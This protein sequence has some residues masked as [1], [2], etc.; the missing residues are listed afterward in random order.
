MNLPG[1]ASLPAR[2]G[3]VATFLLVGALWCLSPMPLHAAPAC[4]EA[5]MATG[6]GAPTSPA[7]GGIG[8]TGDRAESGSMGGT[9]SVASGGIGGTGSVAEGGM[10]GTGIVGTVT[11]F[12]SVCVNGL[13]VDYNPTT[14]ATR[15]GM[16]VKVAELALGQVIA[17][18]AEHGEKGWVARGISMLN[19]LEGP[20][21]AVEPEN[22]LLRVMGQSV[23]ADASTRL[24][25]LSALA[26]ARP[27]M[28]VRVAGFRDHH[29]EVYATRIEA[30]AELDQNSAI[31]LLT[32]SS[33]GV[34][35]LDG[36][37]VRADVP[38]PGLS[39]EFL[40]RGDWDGHAF[41]ASETR[42]APSTPFTDQTR[43][44]IVEGL[45]TQ[46]PAPGRFRIGGFELELPDGTQA[47]SAT[48]SPTPGQRVIVNGHLVGKDRILAQRIDVHAW[49]P[50]YRGLP[51]SARN[52]HGSPGCDGCQTMERATPMERPHMPE[53]P[54]RMEHIPMPGMNMPGMPRMTMP[55][56]PRM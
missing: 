8:G 45:V 34:T 7:R 19:L 15:N 54:Q 48:S 17:I 11:G 24:A 51:G 4:V 23:R 50:M 27:G 12:G 55:G 43:H 46:G 29:G 33:T 3:N 28:L 5:D 21:T 6:T 30:T 9:G 42:P 47:G 26:E 20:V 22:G 31:G 40:L 36:L 37:A 35:T 14:P 18:D 56:M 41:V 16:P 44:I 13:E 53:R 25:G 10:G 49:Q 52:G 38:L 1:P 39:G 2:R 32:R